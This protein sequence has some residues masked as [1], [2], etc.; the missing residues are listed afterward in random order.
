MLLNAF[1]EKEMIIKESK[2]PGFKTKHWSF[3]AVLYVNKL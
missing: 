2:H 3:Y 1:R